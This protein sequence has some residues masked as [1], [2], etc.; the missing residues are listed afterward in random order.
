MHDISIIMTLNWEPKTKF[1]IP[2]ISGYRGSIKV[3]IKIV[4]GL[5]ALGIYSIL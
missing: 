4:V 5:K 1:E 2:R 3:W